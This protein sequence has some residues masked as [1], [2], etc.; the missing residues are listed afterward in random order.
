MSHPVRFGP[1]DTSERTLVVFETTSDLAQLPLVPSFLEALEHDLLRTLGGNRTP[2]IFPRMEAFFPLNYE[3]KPDAHPHQE[4]NGRPLPSCC[5]GYDR[6]S[7]RRS[8]RLILSHSF[9]LAGHDLAVVLR[10][11]AAG[12]APVLTVVAQPC[13]LLHGLW[14]NLRHGT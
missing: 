2:S 11:Q 3:G 12:D 4:K 10:D 8:G 1:S 13:L 5:L 7:N 6:I 9:R 14:M